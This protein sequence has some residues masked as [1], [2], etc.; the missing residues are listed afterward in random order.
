MGDI[1]IGVLCM[2]PVTVM[3]GVLSSPSLL[4]GEGGE[5][6]KGVEE[7]LWFMR[8]SILFVLIALAT[9]IGSIV[10][11]QVIIIIWII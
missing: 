4:Q 11:V 10:W 1:N 6:G 9:F 2:E 7:P 8:A 3:W 5:G